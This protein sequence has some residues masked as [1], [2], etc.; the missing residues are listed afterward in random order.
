MSAPPTYYDDLDD[1][2]EARDVERALVVNPADHDD[3]HGLLPTPDPFA[4]R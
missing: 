3:E 2:D 1:L 4:D